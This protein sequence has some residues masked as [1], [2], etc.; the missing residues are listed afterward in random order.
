MECTVP[1]ATRRNSTCSEGWEGDTLVLKQ[2]FYWSF[3][4]QEYV[5]K[6]LLEQIN[7]LQKVLTTIL[8][9]AQQNAEESMEEFVADKVRKMGAMIGHYSDAFQTLNVMSRKDID[10]EVAKVCHDKSIRDAADELF[11]AEDE[12]NSFLEETDAKI[13]PLCK[14]KAKEL[15][16]GSHGPC[17]L[18]LIDVHTERLA[19]WSIRCL[20]IVM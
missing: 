5:E 19:K 8:N 15:V 13:N 10:E 11:Q 2:H 7:H 1:C 17:D 3:L 4:F 9:E 20:L 18:K 16:E 6:T 14:D 12:W